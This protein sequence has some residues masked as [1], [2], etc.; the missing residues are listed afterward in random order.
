VNRGALSFEQRPLAHASR[1]LGNIAKL[2][3][4]V[5]MVNEKPYKP[6]PAKRL[7]G[8]VGRVRPIT[9]AYD[10]K[11]L[12]ALRTAAV[13]ERDYDDMLAAARLH[14][15]V[16]EAPCYA[17]VLMQPGLTAAAQHARLHAMLVE[18][19]VVS[20]VEFYEEELTRRVARSGPLASGTLDRLLDAAVARFELNAQSSNPFREV[21]GARGADYAELYS[22][23]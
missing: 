18:G 7:R 10:A 13:S 15:H 6:S 23:T 19:D 9:L 4:M 5:G 2:L 3:A 20:H 22:T 17:G 14:A 1:P 16:E 21:E 12:L 8:D 11:K